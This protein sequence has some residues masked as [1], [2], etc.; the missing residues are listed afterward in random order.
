MRQQ[1]VELRRFRVVD[2]VDHVGEPFLWVD[3][4]FFAGSEEAVEHCH[5]LSSLVSSGKEVVFSTQCQGSDGVFNPIVIHFKDAILEVV[6]KTY[7]LIRY[8][9]LILILLN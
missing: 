2:V 6:L 8:A 5:I 1:V 7:L 4:V 3:V 9:L